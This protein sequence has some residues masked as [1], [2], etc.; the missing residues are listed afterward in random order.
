VIEALGDLQ[1]TAYD[2][3]LRAEARL[4]RAIETLAAAAPPTD[5]AAVHATFASALH[6]AREAIERRKQAAA[7]ALASTNQDAAAAA[8]G[9]L[10]LAAQAHQDLVRGLFPPKLR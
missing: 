9:A 7:T 2:T 8:A 3:L 5:L 1:F 6:L 4:G 10:L